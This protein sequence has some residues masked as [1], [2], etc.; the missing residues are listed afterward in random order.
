MN[1]DVKIEGV[2]FGI[3]EGTERRR[4]LA[5]G[6][7]WTKT[8]TTDAKGTSTD[9]IEGVEVEETIKCSGHILAFLVVHHRFPLAEKYNDYDD[10][11]GGGGWHD[12]GGCGGIVVVV[13]GIVGLA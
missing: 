5:R 10:D 8:W 1:N 6:L 13:V 3:M 2:L 7:D 4:D 11:G 12:G 9:K